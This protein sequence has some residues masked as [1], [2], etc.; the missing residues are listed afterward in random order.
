MG[1]IPARRRASAPGRRAP[2]NSASPFA[3]EHQRDVGERREIATGADA[4]LRRNDGR[5]AAIQQIAQAFGDDGPDAG[6]TFGQHIGADEHHAADFVASQRRAHSAGV[7]ADH[8]ALEL[9]QFFG[10]D[11]NVG[12]QSDAGVD[13]VDRGVAERELFDH[14][15]RAEH[16][17][18][19]G[20]VDL[21]GLAQ[22]RDARNSSKV[23]REPSREIMAPTVV[24][25]SAFR[26]T[27]RQAGLGSRD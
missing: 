3:D 9:L 17:G 11:A 4:A 25:T 24:P 20:G 15:A 2:S 6:K 8:V 26:C 10:R 18:E 23:R 1:W 19:S 16:G 5:D 12:E 13:G 22:L 14:G 27:K 7:G 21:H